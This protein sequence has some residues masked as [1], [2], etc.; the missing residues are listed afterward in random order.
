MAE[1]AVRAVTSPVDRLAGLLRW[2][3]LLALIL[4]ALVVIGTIVSPVFLG[5]RNFSNLISAVIEVKIM[6]RV[7]LSSSAARSTSRSS[8]W[9][10]SRAPSSG[11]C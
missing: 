7:A 4:L 5:G 2:E 1:P 9:P 8:R 3:S 11:S 10:V 6:S